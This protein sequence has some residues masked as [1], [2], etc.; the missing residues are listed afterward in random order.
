[1]IPIYVAG[2]FAAQEH[3]LPVPVGLHVTRAAAV[4]SWATRM[5]YAP[6]V[7]HPA[8]AAGAYGDDDDPDDRRMGLAATVELVRLVASHP[9]GELWL[10]TRDD[11]TLS[12][13]TAGELRAWEQH[14][15]LLW[16]QL[17]SVVRI[18]TPMGWWELLEQEQVAPDLGAWQHGRALAVGG[19]GTGGVI[20]TTSEPLRYTCDCGRRMFHWDQRGGPDASSV[21]NQVLAEAVA[22]M[23]RWDHLCPD[24]R[25]EPATVLCCGDSWPATRAVREWTP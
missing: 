1:M 22:A 4:A 16:P 2:P 20:T 21:G 11:G 23:D 5:G 17:A 25:L 13:G 7:V 9:A 15:R 10:I 12:S 19:V 14:R 6:L 24:C 3:P 18:G 8:I